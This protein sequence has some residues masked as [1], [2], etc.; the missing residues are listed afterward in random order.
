MNRDVEVIH[1]PPRQTPARARVD[2]LVCGG[3][4]AGAIAAL[5][6]AQQGASVALVEQQGFCGGVN[7]Y[8][9]VN[10]VGGWQ[11]DLDGRPLI[12]GLPLDVM[13]MVAELGGGDVEQIG[14][15]RR[16]TPDG[17]DYRDGGLGCFWVRTNPEMMK[18]AL[19]RMLKA[20]G[21]HLLYGT[22]V[23]E[24]VLDGH[25]VRGGIIESK[26][27]RQ[28]ILADV[29]IDATG[30]GD[31]AARA[32]AEFEFGRPEDGACQPMTMIFTVGKSNVDKLWFRPDEP[33]PEADPLVRGRYGAAVTLARQRGEITRNPNDILCAAT[34]IGPNSDVQM[35]NFTRI[36]GLSAVDADDLTAAWIVGREQVHEAVAFM[37]KY[38]R[39]CPEAFLISTAGLGLRESRRIAGEYTLTGDDV[40]NGRSF[41]D[42][43]ARGIY[44]LDIHNPTEIGQP[45]TLQMLDAPYG[46]PY[47]CLI[48]R[49]I[50]GL[51]VAG[52]CISGDH[53]ALASYRIQSHCMA[54]GQAAGTAGALSAQY[55]CM[56]RDLPFADL[57]ERL[58]Q[59]GV[60]LGPTA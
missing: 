12:S 6:A 56:P 29:T 4:T 39:G 26:S 5:A 47:R 50:D 23:T 13:Q 57:A 7:T 36:Q 37:R 31:I 16:P 40:L 60:N 11:Y 43:I 15:L 14:R 17:P 58:L 22:M 18:L 42:Q 1:E 20:A 2:V 44:L 24:P 53:V 54:M 19:D 30:D 51:L 10:G 46:I 27:G 3:G 32:G 45:S 8:A 38:V 52:R 49:K 33:D 21:V 35:V 34:Q 41:G 28:A 9:C 25:R 48:P 55:G 59:D